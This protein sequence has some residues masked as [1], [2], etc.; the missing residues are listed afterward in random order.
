MIGVC[1]GDPVG[2]TSFECQHYAHVY[3]YTHLR[4]QARIGVTPSAPE[5]PADP[6][7]R[8]RLPATER[9]AVPLGRMPDHPGPYHIQLDGEEAPAQ[10]LAILDQCR[11]VPTAP[12]RALPGQ[13]T[14]VV[15]SRTTGRVL[16]C[17]RHMARTLGPEKNVRVVPGDHVIQHRDRVPAR[18]LP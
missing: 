5:F 14:V 10:V 15:L 6:R 7:G 4:E 9:A 3:L 11:A 1:V 16:H 12:K 17:S 13:A 2:K 18:G 8:A